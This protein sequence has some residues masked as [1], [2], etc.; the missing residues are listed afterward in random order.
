MPSPREL[1]QKA[2]VRF[3]ESNS[4]KFDAPFGVIEGMEK[5]GNGKLRTITFGVARYLDGE[6]RIYKENDI[7]IRGSGALISKYGG[8]YKSVKEVIDKL[9][10]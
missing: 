1:A 5:F 10:S 2:I 3:L 6:I 4:S 9:N 7:E 8:R